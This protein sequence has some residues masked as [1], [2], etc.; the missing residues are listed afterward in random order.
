MTPAVESPRETVYRTLTELVA[1]H[2]P[3]GVEAAVDAYLLRR[4]AEHG[5]P[6]SDGAGNIVFR[7]EGRDSGPLRS[8][9]A[10]KDEIG[11]IIKRVN[12]EGRLSV[13]KL[14]GS[15]PWIWGE[16]PVD[17]LGRNATISG[18]LSF[19]ARHVSDE[20]DQKR[21]QDDAGVR[22]R[23]AWVETKLDTAALTAAG[24]RPGS[25]VV[26]SAARKRPV[27]LGVDGEYVASYA[28]D[29]KG[30]VAGLLELAGR[31]DSPP[32]PVELVFTA[33]EEIGCHGA[34][35]YASRTAAEAAVAFEVT[36][37]AKEYLIEAGPDP[38]LVVADA[39]GPLDDSLAGELDAAAAAAGVG[40]R[41][42]VLSGFG[43]DASMALAG[44]M[45]ARTA[46]LAFATENTH[47]F[48]IAHLDGI[49]ACVDV[50][51]RWLSG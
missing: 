38:V 21:Q 41:H 20:S 46:C 18:V 49:T 31:L 6:A 30:A 7:I 17:V 26:P 12:E 16:G 4:L 27:R 44:G 42:A 36:P 32:H 34:K 9:L 13:S 35:W 28:I 45:I 23:D 37:V 50:L 14:G 47:G 10:H 25:R 3:S 24:V 22:W 19:G 33:R 43:S 48:E 40:M 11:A 39:L 29:D 51:E 8:V 2:S 5:N 1:L 15:F